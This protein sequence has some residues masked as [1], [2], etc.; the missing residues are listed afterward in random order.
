MCFQSEIRVHKYPA[1]I[2][3]YSLPPVRESTSQRSGGEEGRE[4]LCRNVTTT[5][6]LTHLASQHEKYDPLA[7]QPRTVR[8]FGGSSYGPV[9]G[10]GLVEELGPVLFG[11]L[12][13]QFCMRRL[14][15]YNYDGPTW[16]ALH[17]RLSRNFHHHHRVRRDGIPPLDNVYTCKSY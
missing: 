2:K 7:S 4:F 1:S 13:W 8:I 5:P 9:R 6:D 12:P 16:P 17:R 15:D 10:G 11:S 14:Q 3:L